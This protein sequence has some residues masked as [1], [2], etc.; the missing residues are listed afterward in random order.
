MQE[1]SLKCSAVIGGIR[2]IRLRLSEFCARRIYIGKSTGGTARRGLAIARGTAQR[3]RWQTKAIKSLRSCSFGKRHGCA[4]PCPFQKWTRLYS[5]F[6]ILHVNTAFWGYH[7]QCTVL[8]H[9]TICIL[10][11]IYLSK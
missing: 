5:V 1:D 9:C 3:D 4:G 8:L 6:I 10:G 2:P 7:A 11:A